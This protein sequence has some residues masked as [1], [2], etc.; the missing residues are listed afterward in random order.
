MSSTEG[1]QTKVHHPGDKP[2]MWIAS[3]NLGKG[4]ILLIIAMSFLGFLHKDVD[5][6]VGRWISWLGIN[7]DNP[8]VAAFLDRL[9]KVT[10]HQIRILSGITSVFSAVFITEGIGLFF[11]Q[12]WAE[13]LTVI[14]TACFVP[15]ELFETFKHF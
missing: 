10:D 12:R 4:I 15:V 7:L 14:V 13:Y 6:I 2:L 11:K 3:Y 1:S 5:A 9:D 8:H